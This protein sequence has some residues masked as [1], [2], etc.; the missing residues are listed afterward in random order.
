MIIFHHVPKTGGTFVVKCLT[1]NLANSNKFPKKCERIEFNKRCR[2]PQDFIEHKRGQIAMVSSH[3][4]FGPKTFKKNKEDFYISW[5]RD[6][7]EMFFSA[8]R[9]YRGEG[10]WARNVAKPERLRKQIVLMQDCAGLEDYVKKCEQG[11]DFFP[12]GS[13]DELNW[14]K[15]DFVG[16]C[17]NMESDLERLCNL[18]GIKRV[19]VPAPVMVSQR[20]EEEKLFYNR[21][22]TLLKN[23]KKYPKFSTGA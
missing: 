21:V 9:F 1:E 23:T 2:S 12:C 20:D 11:T 7:V 8:W 3:W 6:P 22:K 19:A 14:G 18:L 4:A 5:R 13:I 15:F 17:E 16:S 10:A